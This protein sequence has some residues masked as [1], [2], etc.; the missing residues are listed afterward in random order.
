MDRAADPAKATRL[1]GR[2]H[3]AVRTAAER[4]RTAYQS[5]EATITIGI[6]GPDAA[7]RTAPLRAVL[8]PLAAKHGWDLSEMP[9]DNEKG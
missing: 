1:R 9:T 7:A 4:R 3:A 2:I 5:T 6:S 8:G